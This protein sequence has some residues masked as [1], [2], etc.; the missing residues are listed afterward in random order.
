MGNLPKVAF[1]PAGID[2]CAL[3]R[4]F[5]P[6]LHMPG[7]K[8]IFRPGKMRPDEYDGCEIGVVQRLVTQDNLIA[9]NY[10]RE[11]GMK[12]IY[13]L[14]D[15]MWAVPASNP[16]KKLI[17]QYRDG[18]GV[19]AQAS[20]VITV[21]TRGLRSALKGALPG[22]QQEVYVVPNA[23][24]F[25]LF[26][27]GP[28][29]CD[30]GRVVVGWAG[31]NT[32]G[33]D[34]KDAMD[35]L[36]KML[37]KHENLYLEFVGGTTAP[38]LQGHKR[39]VVRSW[40]PVGEFAVRFASWMWD[41]ALAPLE[42]NRFNRSK[43]CIKMLESAALQIPCL[44]GR[45]Q[46]YEEFCALGGRELEWLLCDGR[47]EWEEKLEKLITNKEFRVEMGRMVYETAKKYFDIE[48]LIENWK[49]VF[50]KMG[51]M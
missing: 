47:K 37:E 35:V 49:F 5:I 14:D 45:V 2:A 15:N 19:C 22:L 7:S 4:M 18:F 11:S 42:D 13:D 44:A 38:K 16:G 48:T 34:L 3:Y 31:S 32:H 40:V 28:V 46:P 39:V 27:Q 6:H 50:Q 8:F 12:V 1:F 33:E 17:E 24:D 51:V 9:I 36:P 20:D 26:R 29:N 23:M 30:D 10:M 41:I 21:S 43:S 25:R